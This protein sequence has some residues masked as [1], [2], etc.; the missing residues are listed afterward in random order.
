VKTGKPGWGL[1]LSQEL[2]WRAVVFSAAVLAGFIFC[3]PDLLI[4][5]H[6]SFYQRHF[7]EAVAQWPLGGRYTSISPFDDRDANSYAARVNE[8][9]HH[10]WPMDPNIKENRNSRRLLL[11]DTLAF[12]FLG[13]LQRL[14]GDISRGW[15]LARGVAGF[16]WLSTLYLVIA[17]A[18]GRKR[19][20]LALAAIVTLFSDLFIDIY[21][22][23]SIFRDPQIRWKFIY[24][25]LPGI[26]NMVTHALWI[27]GNY[28]DNLGS[29]RLVSPGLNLP[30]FFLAS[31]L[32]WKTAQATSRAAWTWAG[33]GGLLGGVMVYVHPDVW[34]VYMAA[35]GLFCVLWSAQSQRVVWPLCVSFILSLCIS[36]PWLALNYPVDHDILIRMG[37]EYSPLFDWGGVFPLALGITALWAWRR[38]PAAA[39]VACVSAAIFISMESQVKTDFTVRSERFIFIGATLAVALLAK[40]LAGKLSENRRWLWVT[41]V[42]FILAAGRTVSYAAQRYPYQGLPP[43]LDAAFDYL[44]R[45][46]PEDS[47]VVALG[48]QETMLIPVYTHDKTLLASGYTTTCDIP[49]SDI[50]QRMHLALQLSGINESSFLDILS[51]AT[52]SDVK[53]DIHAHMGQS[54]EQAFWEGQV[55]WQSREWDNFF[56][57]YFVEMELNR[58]APGI[59]GG[60]NSASEREFGKRRDIISR[61]RAGEENASQLKP[62]A[63]YLWVGPFERGLMKPGELKKLGRPI[64]ENAS[65]SIYKVS[66]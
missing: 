17:E 8:A 35:M 57:Y 13:G 36:F 2:G 40:G 31:Y 28:Q 14:T 27:M 10:L 24:Y 5:Q 15:L 61:L 20:A 1:A 6:R 3:L 52:V 7:P 9:A 45:V 26:K 32:A 49:I 64:Y 29:S 47:V 51:K 56:P 48:P 50:F 55:D 21:T 30:P 42:V 19:A 22:P 44:N 65:I 37:G 46:T 16:L 25:I 39:Y 11:T 12:M 18:S 34:H 59:P 38:E 66:A 63:D 41:A 60:P 33:L 4:M 54:W 23:V 43:D 53:G 62:E 58:K